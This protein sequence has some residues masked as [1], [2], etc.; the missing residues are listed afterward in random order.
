[1]AETQ[2]ESLVPPSAPAPRIP[3]PNPNAEGRARRSVRATDAGRGDGREP[4]RTAAREVD[5]ADEAA[6]R[7]RTRRGAQAD[8]FY[9]NPEKIPSGWDYQWKRLSCLNQPDPGYEVMLY[10]QA[11]TPVP[12]SRHP[13]MV[14][15]GYKGTTIERDGMILMERPMRLTKEAQ[16]EELAEARAR[17]ANRKL[18]LGETPQGTL[19]RDH[20]SARRVTGV[21]SEFAP[22]A[23]D[24]IPGDE[25][26]QLPA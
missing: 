1:M 21:R 13:E 12:A 25:E 19:P 20:E 14:P 2:E 18:Q 8:K 23:A 16:M 5:R 11:F 7:K 24:D 6:A 9:V 15:P 4:V 10:E 3:A 22:L 26:I 17:I